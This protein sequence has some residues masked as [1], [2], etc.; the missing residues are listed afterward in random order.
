VIRATAPASTANLGPG[1]D[2]AGAA[3]D[4]WN[5][6][7][8][9]EGPFGVEISGEGAGELPRDEGHLALR[10][11]AVVAPVS[12]YRFRFVNRIPLERGLGSSAAAIALGLVAGA[13]AAGLD[14]SADELL[15]LAARFE[16]HL[17]NLA[18]ALNGGVCVAWCEGRGPHARRVAD[19]VPAS[20]V[21]VVP[22]ARTS[23]RASRAALPEHVPHADAAATAGAAV[24]L[25]AALAAGD[26]SLLRPALRDRLHE[27]YRAAAAPLLG[28][29]RE[30]A[31]PGL[32]GATLSGSGP[33]VIAW[34]DPSAVDEAAALLERSLGDVARVLPLAVADRG[35]TA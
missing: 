35:A 21:A 30:L 3:L 7:E 20:P 9:E 22:A 26:A 10:A 17:D 4:L 6:L 25:G 5:E 16:P 8:A 1:F 13:R 24:L 33:T 32:L 15:G 27:P 12:G 18:A 34:V 14:P 29:V 11:F 19:R 28:R 31:P 2:A 23:T